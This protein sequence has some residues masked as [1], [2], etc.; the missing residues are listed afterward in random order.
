MSQVLL[1]LMEPE[2]NKIKATVKEEVTREVTKIGIKNT[3][4]ALKDCG[5]TDAAIKQ[6]IIKTYHISPKEAKDYL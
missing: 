4:L 1:E 6:A 2:I 5:Q 3:V